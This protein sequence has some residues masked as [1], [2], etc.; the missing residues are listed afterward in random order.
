MRSVSR[1]EL[2]A[3]FLL[4]IILFASA[5]ALVELHY[6]SRLLF[7][8]HE[9]EVGIARR[10]LD[11]QAELQ[12][13]VRRAALPGTIS[14]GAQ[15][16]VRRAALPG[17]ISAGAQMM[18]LEGA[19]GAVTYTLVADAQGRIDF[20]EETKARVERAEALEREKAAAA[21]AA[22]AERAEKAARRAKRSDAAKRTGGER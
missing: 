4:G 16:K 9:H 17:T 6:R 15:M 21:E 18:G 2:I 10:L 13:K 20:A 7:V 5:I 12:M 8:E 3:V 14:A 19:T 11:D 1:A 22:K